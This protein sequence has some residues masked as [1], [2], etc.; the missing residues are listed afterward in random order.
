VTGAPRVAERID[1]LAEPEA[2]GDQD[3]YGMEQGAT[4]PREPDWRS[5]L[6]LADTSPLPPPSPT[7]RPT[8]PSARD[9]RGK[10]ARVRGCLA[11]DFDFTPILKFTIPEEL[12]HVSIEIEKKFSELEEKLRNVSASSQAYLPASEE[13]IKSFI[14]EREAVTKD[15][16]ATYK[17]A[18]K[19]LKDLHEQGSLDRRTYKRV[20]SELDNSESILALERG[21][22]AM[23]KARIALRISASHLDQTIG[24]AYRIAIT[25]QM[26]I[27]TQATIDLGVSKSSDQSNFRAKLINAY[28]DP[29]DKKIEALWCPVT[30]GYPIA[31]DVLVKAAH[32]VPFAI[33]ETNAAYIFGVELDEGFDCVWSEK[34]GLLL[35]TTVKKALEN[36]QLVIIPRSDNID[37]LRVVLLDQ[38]IADKI[39]VEIGERVVCFKDVG[40]LEFKTLARPGR[41]NLYFNTLL[42]VLRRK[43]HGV[44]GH[45][46]DFDKLSMSDN[47]IW[48]TPEKWM[49]RSILQALAAEIGDVFTPDIMNNIIGVGDMAHQ[50]SPEKESQ[51]VATIRYGL[52]YGV[53]G[54]EDNEDDE[55]GEG[56]EGDEF[57]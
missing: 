57:Y 6:T 8:W 54:E 19:V 21:A 56:N 50:E 7:L 44:P 28:G 3:T 38:T 48:A 40:D 4:R 18:K 33:G 24:E 47:A 29:K 11:A 10:R 43:R 23:W 36:A 35:H 42:A 37:I 53:P 46:L 20:R 1:A 41:C 16:V 31:S 45:E 49:R 15:A 14:T 51:R 17:D 30:R 34:N 55:D 27:P 13:K 52:E 39:I 25:D 2:E 9:R 12:R 22:I 32:L 26:K 5:G